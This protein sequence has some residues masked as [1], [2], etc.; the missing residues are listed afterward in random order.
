MKCCDLLYFA[1]HNFELIQQ[2]IMRSN[3][4]SELLYLK[5]GKCTV[6]YQS[7]CIDAEAND[8][9]IIPA[10]V[11]YR[12]ETKEKGTLYL[13]GFDDNSINFGKRP[14][15]YKKYDNSY[16]LSLINEIHD[17]FEGY[18]LHRKQ[19]L[20]L[21]LN[22]VLINLGRNHKACDTKKNLESDNFYF[23]LNLMN[24]H[25][26]NGIDINYVALTCGLSYHR[27][28][29]RFKEL[30]GISP[31]QYIIKQ[32]L[33][34]AKRLLETTDYNTSLIAEACDFHSVPQFITCFS[35]EEGL[36]PV[37]YRKYYRSKKVPAQIAL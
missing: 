7:S 31:Q 23:V 34:F 3:A 5:S 13:I 6:H 21:L 32:R 12:F 2:N 16:V 20:C 10:N 28:R 14:S 4:H 18:K 24:S 26:N 11:N 35:K 1:E 9:V 36:T 15:I 22:I 29:H 8:I 27:F 19:M 33:N 17:E 37:K 30:V 25:S